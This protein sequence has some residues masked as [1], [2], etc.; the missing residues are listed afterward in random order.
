MTT[1]NLLNEN[2]ETKRKIMK[3]LQTLTLMKDKTQ[4]RYSSRQMNVL[5]MVLPLC[6]ASQEKTNKAKRK[7]MKQS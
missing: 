4:L 7:P 5:D 1:D 3:K 2:G 6:N